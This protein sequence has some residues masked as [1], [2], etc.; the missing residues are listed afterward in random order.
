MTTDAQIVVGLDMSTDKKK[1][2]VALGRIVGGRL[3]IERVGNGRILREVMHDKKSALVAIDSPLGWPVLM[4]TALCGHQV[5]EKIA[6]SRAF[7][8][9][10]NTDLF[11]GKRLPGITPFWV[12]ADKIGCTAHAACELLSGRGIRVL[13]EM[14]IPKGLSAIEV[15]PS[16]TLCAHGWKGK[17]RGEVVEKLATEEN[18]V[19][20]GET[21]QCVKTQHHFDACICLLAARDFWEKKC[22]TPKEA[23]ATDVAKVE[24]W[25]WVR[26]KMGD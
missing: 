20:L 15:Y 18:V 24:G 8:F 3:E 17:E 21:K 10:R 7:I 13:L 16:A 11:V 19:F 26:K 5:G 14:K 4:R 12:G 2:G 23:N 25:I 6:K 22:Y 9:Q 1:Q